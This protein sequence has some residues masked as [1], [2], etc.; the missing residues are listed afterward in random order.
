[1]KNYLYIVLLAVLFSCNGYQKIVKSNDIELKYIMAKKYYEED[2]YFKALP[3]LDELHTLFKGTK[4]AEE[5]DYLLAYTHYG[6]GANM[7]ASYKFKIFTLTY[8]SS[9]HNEELSFM[10]AYCYYLESPKYSLDK[11]NTIKAIQ[12]LQTFI[13]NYPESDKV[14]ECNAL[15]DDLTEKVHKKVY[16]IA[17]L[18][19]D[20]EDYNAAITALN[21]VIT[22]YPTI[23][24]QSEIQFLILDAN[25]KLAINSV[26]NKKIERL[27][28]TIA[29][30]RYFSKN[31]PEDEKLKDAQNIYEKSIKQLEKF[32]Q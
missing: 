6:L 20:I 13:N 3:L 16:G 32:Q 17:K 30:Y 28:N 2:E 19:Y 29:S 12:E 31:F 7:L 10:A 11:T 4:K 5:V 21:N 26:T 8:P 18:Y 14:A 27:N 15:I 22:D 25:Y 24:N 23:E 9:K 1:M